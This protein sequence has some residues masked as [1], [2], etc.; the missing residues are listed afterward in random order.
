MVC[1]QQRNRVGHVPGRTKWM[2]QAPACA[3]RGSYRRPRSTVGT[4]GRC[5]AA[6]GGGLASGRLRKGATRRGGWWPGTGSHGITLVP[7]SSVTPP[8]TAYTGPPGVSVGVRINWPR[9]RI[10]TSLDADTSRRSCLM[11][12]DTNCRISSGV[13]EMLTG[14]TA[15]MWLSI[16]ASSTSTCANLARG[17]G[18]WPASEIPSVNRSALACSSRRCW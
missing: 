13:A 16:E 14:L 11:L 15:L 1:V 9:C 5:W 10:N 7:V 4:S 8:G 6:G 2:G 3:G 12:A 17:A 18:E